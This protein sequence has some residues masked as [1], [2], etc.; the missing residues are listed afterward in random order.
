[1]WGARKTSSKDIEQ[2][3]LTLT[4]FACPGMDELMSEFSGGNQTVKGL[5]FQ[6]R[7]FRQGFSKL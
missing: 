3:Y 6:E 2:I 1:M 4:E 5:E 7:S